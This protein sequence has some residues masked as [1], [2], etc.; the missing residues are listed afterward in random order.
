MT[1]HR[2]QLAE[3]ATNLA[4]LVGILQHDP[5]CQWT[6]HF[7]LCLA[8]IELLAAGNP[9]Q[10]E[11]NELSGSVMHVFG[12]MG[13]FNDYAPWQNGRTIPG[14][15]ALTDASAKVYQSALSLRVV[16]A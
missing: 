15:E 3:L 9:S 10:S 13:S 11:I 14:M 6:R 1:D 5:S 2:T 12:G 16:E 4:E 8:S 7:E